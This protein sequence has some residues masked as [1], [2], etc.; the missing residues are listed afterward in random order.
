MMELGDLSHKVGVSH[1][2]FCFDLPQEDL[3]DFIPVYLYRKKLSTCLE[4]TKLM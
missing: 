2:H 3:D 4:R 1:S